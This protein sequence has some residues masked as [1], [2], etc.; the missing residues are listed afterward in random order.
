MMKNPHLIQITKD[1][2]TD[3]ML[4]KW[5]GKGI[6]QERKNMLKDSVEG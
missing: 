6:A 4:G 5:F 3:M 1:N 2:M